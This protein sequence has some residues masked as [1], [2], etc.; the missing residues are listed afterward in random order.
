MCVK[1]TSNAST[2][3]L[4]LLSIFY[5]LDSCKRNNFLPL[6][7]SPHETAICIS[8]I[9]VL[10]LHSRKGGFTDYGKAAFLFA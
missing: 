6:R 2:Y 4:F 5:R 3:F 7:F 8:Q 9:I 1:C 10:S